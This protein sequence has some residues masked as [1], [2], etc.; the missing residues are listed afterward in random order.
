MQRP[1]VRAASPDSSTA[2]VLQRGAVLMRQRHRRYRV[3]RHRTPHVRVAQPL[4]LVLR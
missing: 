4:Q 1:L 3:P 2:V